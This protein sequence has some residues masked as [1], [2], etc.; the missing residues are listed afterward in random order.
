MHAG[1]GGLLLPGL[2][3]GSEDPSF[4]FGDGDRDP[5]YEPIGLGV[6]AGVSAVI[7]ERG[8]CPVDAPDDGPKV[9]LMA[10]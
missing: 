5:E 1:V 10:A 7:Y 3:A 9:L 4:V 6:T 2:R 8:T